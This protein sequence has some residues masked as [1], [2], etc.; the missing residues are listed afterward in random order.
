MAF[1]VRKRLVAGFIAGALGL[2]VV[3]EDGPMFLSAL[4]SLS[5]PPGKFGDRP[6]DLKPTS[7]AQ[8]A[9]DPADP[10]PLSIVYAKTLGLVPGAIVCHDYQTTHDVYEQY[11]AS[12]EDSMRYGIANV[13]THGHARE[14]LG[15][16]PSEF[17]FSTYDC[18]LVRPGTPI[19]LLGYIYDQI[20]IVRIRTPQG[21]LTKGVTLPDM[22][23]TPEK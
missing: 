10:K 4:Q 1:M 6:K 12:L 21:G 2:L 15:D 18:R 20:P 16:P 8:P 14:L 7:M 11:V 19:E 22:I 5:A 23:T 13:Q 3:V 17:D 9:A